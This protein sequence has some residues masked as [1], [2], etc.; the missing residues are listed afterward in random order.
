MTMSSS[1]EHLKSWIN[2]QNTYKELKYIYD[3]KY[4][5]RGVY[6]KNIISTNHRAERKYLLVLFLNVLM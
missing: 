4:Y 1:W 6:K 3:A 5:S 2:I